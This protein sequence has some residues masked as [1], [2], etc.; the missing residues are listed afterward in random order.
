MAMALGALY[1]VLINVD[2]YN[3]VAD[4]MKKRDNALKVYETELRSVEAKKLQVLEAIDS[5]LDERR[6]EALLQMMKHP[7]RLDA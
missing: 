3:T 2:E 1:N 7:E 5:R 4:A 6:A